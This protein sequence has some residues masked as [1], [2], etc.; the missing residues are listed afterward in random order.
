M[1]TEV[2]LPNLAKVWP[3]L[4][5]SLKLSRKE[6]Y[7]FANRLPAGVLVRLGR[8]LRVDVDRFAEWSAAGGH[9]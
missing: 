2:S 9:S 6:A 1:Q 3:E 7:E 4:G 5:T 8:R